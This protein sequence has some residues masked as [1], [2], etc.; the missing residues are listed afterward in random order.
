MLPPIRKHSIWKNQTLFV[1]EQLG[2]STFSKQLLGKV[3]FSISLRAACINGKETLTASFKSLSQLTSFF[4]KETSTYNL[5]NRYPS[6]RWAKNTIKNENK[7]Q[8]IHSPVQ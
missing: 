7:T 6:K 4:L 3:P 2:I 1:E 5:L 8:K